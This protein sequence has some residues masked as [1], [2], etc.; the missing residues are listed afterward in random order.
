MLITVGYKNNFG[1]II[2]AAIALALAIFIFTVKDAQT[3]MTQIVG[4]V[5]IIAGLICLIPSL[6][7]K[8]DAAQEAKAKKKDKGKSMSLVLASIT[9]GIATLVGLVLVLWPAKVGHL[10]F[11]VISGML[12]ILV[13]LEI[14]V[15]VSTYIFM[16][17]LHLMGWLPLALGIIALIFALIFF[18]NP[19]H[20]KWCLGIGLLVY[21]IS[22]L[23][24]MFRISKAENEYEIRFTA[25]AQAQ[26]AAIPEDKQPLSR[27]RSVVPTDGV[28]DV[29]FES[30]DRQ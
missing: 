18:L 17:P 16:K 20:I 22:E 15:L 23:I 13:A 14:V 7:S 29:D 19:T 6:T 5:I 10:L 2:R 12:I 25:E 30:V 1:T 9:C 21:G 4:V 8:D 26:R 27:D 11:V 24:S 3:Y 28:K